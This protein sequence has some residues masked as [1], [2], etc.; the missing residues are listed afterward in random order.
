MIIVWKTPRCICAIFHFDWANILFEYYS[1]TSDLIYRMAW[2]LLNT[3]YL[4]YR[5]QY[6]SAWFLERFFLK[7]KLP[8]SSLTLPNSLKVVSFV[9][10]LFYQLVLSSTLTLPNSTFGYI[11]TV[12]V[13]W[14]PFSHSYTIWTKRKHLIWNSFSYAFFRLAYSHTFWNPLIYYSMNAKVRKYLKEDIMNKS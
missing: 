9:V 8:I 4:N 11:H 1:H 13:W 7:V 2:P 3:A 5:N 10:H 14:A 6:R 12:F